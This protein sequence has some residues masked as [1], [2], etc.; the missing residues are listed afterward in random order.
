MTPVQRTRY[1]ECRK[2]GFCRCREC[3]PGL[4]MP[5]ARALMLRT[6]PASSLRLSV[7][8]A[9]AGGVNGRH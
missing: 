3:K 8:V 5:S 1:A 4:A 6:E 7:S 9:I 2:D